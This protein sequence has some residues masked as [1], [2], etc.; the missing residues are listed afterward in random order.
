L[1][2]DKYSV[3]VGRLYLPGQKEMKRPTW[4][5]FYG[6]KN[7]VKSAASAKYCTPKNALKVVRFPLS[8]TIIKE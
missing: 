8:I 3:P 7:A 4:K 5:V 2:H 1:Q 6:G